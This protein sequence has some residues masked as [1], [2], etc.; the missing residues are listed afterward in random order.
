MAQKLSGEVFQTRN[1][2]CKCT[3]KYSSA[4]RSCSSSSES[5]DSLFSQELS[6]SYSMELCRIARDMFPDFFDTA[7]MK[8]PPLKEPGKGNVPGCLE[9]SVLSDDIFDD[10]IKIWLMNEYGLFMYWL[11]VRVYLGLI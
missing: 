8:R 10:K 3:C 2:F 9:A 5:D 4:G 1:F 7:A 6:K 11:H